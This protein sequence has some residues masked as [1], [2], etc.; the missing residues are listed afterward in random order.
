M[1]TLED[2]NKIGSCGDPHPCPICKKITVAFF[3][4][5]DCLRKVISELPPY[6]KDKDLCSKSTKS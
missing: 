6:E 2:Y 3:S 1:E 4:C 5:D